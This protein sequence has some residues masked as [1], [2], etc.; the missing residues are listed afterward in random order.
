[1]LA[2]EVP[3][4]KY[5]ETACHRYSVLFETATAILRSVCI[6]S[7]TVFSMFTTDPIDSITITSPVTAAGA[8]GAATATRA[9]MKKKRKDIRYYCY[10]Y[11]SQTKFSLVQ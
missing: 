6:L 2:S 9:R 1:M 11:Y 4:E 7:K 3:D 5:T 8:A 10:Y